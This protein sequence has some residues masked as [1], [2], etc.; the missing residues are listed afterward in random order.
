MEKVCE[1][2][3]KKFSDILHKQHYANTLIYNLRLRGVDIDN[4]FGRAVWNVENLNGFGYDK[5]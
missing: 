4:E 5:S 2:I 3:T 1:K